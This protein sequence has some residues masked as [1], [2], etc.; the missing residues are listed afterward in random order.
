[1]QTYCAPL[2]ISPRPPW[3]ARPTGW[4]LLVYR[5]TSKQNLQSTLGTNSPRILQLPVAGA[6]NLNMR[7][8]Q[9]NMTLARVARR[10][11][12]I[13][14]LGGAP[15]STK[16]NDARPREQTPPGTLAGTP[17]WLFVT[18]LFPR[19]QTI[20]VA[21]RTLPLDKKRLKRNVSESPLRCRTGHTVEVAFASG[22]LTRGPLPYV[23]SGL[24]AT[25]KVKRHLTQFFRRLTLTRRECG[26]VSHTPPTVFIDVFCRAGPK[27]LTNMGES[28]GEA[29]LRCTL[30]DVLEKS[31]DALNLTDV[32]GHC[33]EHIVHVQSDKEHEL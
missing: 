30:F 8:H 32:S 3:E 19:R 27:L 1:M 26:G 25:C 21:P 29:R 5:K 23:P 7:E 14:R 15:T 6:P 22:A 12:E 31:S 9:P 17:R 2:D 16:S 28:S 33:S 18:D 20:Q 13:E 11:P 10:R 4:E 24:R